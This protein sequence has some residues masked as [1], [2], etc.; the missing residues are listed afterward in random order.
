[1][2]TWLFFGCR[3]LSYLKVIAGFNRDPCNAEGFWVF[4]R[5]TVL[6]LMTTFWGS[7]SASSSGRWNYIDQKMRLTK[8][9]ETSSSLTVPFTAEKPRNLQHYITLHYISSIHSCHRTL[10]MKHVKEC[11]SSIEYNQQ[12][13]R[14]AQHIYI[15][16]LCQPSA[17]PY[18]TCL[19]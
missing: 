6:L 3:T 15:Y 11:N 5:W 8:G 12:S 13:I 10:D 2:E 9:L 4:Q 16:T 1:M 18:L 7:W 17:L 14:T 19:Y